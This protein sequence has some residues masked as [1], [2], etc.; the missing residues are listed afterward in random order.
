MTVCIWTCCIYTVISSFLSLYDAKVIGFTFCLGP[1]VF[2]VCLA[3]MAAVEIQI[4]TL[5]FRE[6]SYQYSTEGGVLPQSH[7]DVHKDNSIADH[8][9]GDV[10]RCRP[11]N[12]ILQ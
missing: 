6:W 7:S 9:D 12:L 4:G 10:L 2:C 1:S 11:V 8:E 3:K 5:Y